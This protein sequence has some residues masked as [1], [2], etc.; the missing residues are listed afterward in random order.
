MGK[1]VEKKRKTESAEAFLR[2]MLKER[3]FLPKEPDVL[4]AWE[5]FKAMCD[6]SFDCSED[7]LLFE[8]GIYD[9][10]G[11]EMFCLSIVR[12]FTII[13][14]EGEYDYIEQLHMDFLYEPEEML[15]DLSETIWTYDFDDD[16]GKFFDAVER[17]PAFGAV[18]N[19]ASAVEF[20][21]Y[22]DEI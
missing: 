14:E 7:E 11:K 16:F 19:G 2:G 1:V 18:R 3:G 8:A 20:E 9:Y 10:S 12:Q 6:V 22:F 17:C 15:R 4:V 5:T 13:E 21:M